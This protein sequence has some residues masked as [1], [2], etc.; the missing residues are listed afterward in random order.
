MVC[1]QHGGMGNGVLSAWSYGE[2]CLVSMEVWGMV[3]CQHGAMGNGVLSAWS[4][5]EWCVVRCVVN[6]EKWVGWVFSIRV[7]CF[8]PKHCVLCMN[9]SFIHSTNGGA[10]ETQTIRGM[11]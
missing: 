8:E 6:M 1:C 5:G 11:S 2:W 3:C 7:V 4:Y 10:V 9:P